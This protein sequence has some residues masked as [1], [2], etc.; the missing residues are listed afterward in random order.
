MLGV[1]WFWT[2]QKMFSGR[3]LTDGLAIASTQFGLSL[4]QLSLIPIL[5]ALLVSTSQLVPHRYLKHLLN[6]ETHFY[7]PQA[8]LSLEH[9][10]AECIF[11]ELQC[12]FRTELKHLHNVE[13]H[14]YCPQTSLSLD[15][16]CRDHVSELK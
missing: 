4:A 7:C 2:T 6:V 14:L 8:F 1:V 16:Q 13:T 5:P 10:T 9:S 15:F 3:S 12:T 11:S